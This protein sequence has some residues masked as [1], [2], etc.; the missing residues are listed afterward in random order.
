MSTPS[1]SPDFDDMVDEDEQ[2]RTFERV[3]TLLRRTDDEHDR[4]YD[5]DREWN[6]LADRLDLSDDAGAAEQRRPTT[7][8]AARAPSVSPAA[9]LQ[10]WSRA[11]AVAVLLLVAAGAGVWWWQQPVSVRTAPGE[12]TVVTLPDGSTAELNGATTLSY[13]RGFSAWPGVE[14][15]VRRVSLDGEA[16]FSVTEQ[17]R[18]FRVETA[19]ARVEVLGTAFHVQARTTDDRP[20][21]RVVVASGRVQLSSADA[22]R[23]DAAP[24]TLERAGQ[25]SRVQGTAAPTG[26]EVVQ[27]KYVEAW[28]Q[29][30]FAVFDAP[31]PAILRELER[32]FGVSV[33]LRIPPAET[34]PMSLHYG[35]DAELDDILRDISFTQGL[36]F[37]R[38]SRGYELVRPNR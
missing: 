36:S 4:S 3:W 33:E 12:Q 6:R 10:R 17:D 21:T 14:A 13:P 28:R 26:P 27:L 38:T 24:V 25:A 11:L 7:D 32:R 34:E 9:R 16:F 19:N 2:A 5:V 29:G 31:L 1:T 37:R 30:G 15:S 8:R 35:Q 23:R 18:P 20:E 22:S